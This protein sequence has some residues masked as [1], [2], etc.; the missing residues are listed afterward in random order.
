M[1][2]VGLLG[3]MLTG[4]WMQVF[5]TAAQQDLSHIDAIDVV[6]RVMG[7][8]KDAAVNPLIILDCTKDFFGR[9]LGDA[10]ETLKSLRQQPADKELF[11][12][13]MS[14]CIHAIV[15]VLE[16]Q[17]RRYLEMEVTDELREETQT[18]R[19]HNI[20]SE[21]LMGMFSTGKEQ[22]KNVNVDFLTARMRARK[23][24]VVP[25]LDEMFDEKRKHIVM[26][27]I[28]RARRK[29]RANR[30]KVDAVRKEMS[31]RAANK[32]QKKSE[33]ERKAVEKKL[34][35]MDI[36]DI[37]QVFPE[38]EQNVCSMLSD[39]LTGRVVGRTICHTWYDESTGEKTVWSGKVEKQRR[40]SGTNFY[41]IAYWSEDETYKDSTDYD[42][43]KI[44]LATDLIFADLILC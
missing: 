32:R 42:I 37:N 17:Y 2:I 40:R 24:Q 25:W 30:N 6:R 15:D 29:R 4:P 16:R 7:A 38:L 8:L 39:I 5:Y 43:P 26:W 33:K 20:N 9:D 28:G 41:S 36:N 19:L 27:S 34:K 18:A 11:C 3:K 1:H 13:M 44:A 21:E 23:N 12:S 22:A 14:T 35:E 31:V 10:D